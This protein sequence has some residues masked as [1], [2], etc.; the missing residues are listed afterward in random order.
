[1]TRSIALIAAA[2]ALT[3]GA[4]HAQ[5]ASVHINAGKLNLNNAAD[6]RFSI[7]N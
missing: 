2:F 7:G 1:M 3:V 6:A 4:A 5:E